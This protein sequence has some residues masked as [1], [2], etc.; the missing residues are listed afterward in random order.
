M[1][2]AILEGGSMGQ[3][4]VLN[5]LPVASEVFVE[6][7]ID[8]LVKDRLLWQEHVG[9]RAYPSDAMPSVI[10]IVGSRLSSLR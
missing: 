3:K 4:E 1:G 7:H 6:L 8:D 9:R 2:R 10:H 5:Q